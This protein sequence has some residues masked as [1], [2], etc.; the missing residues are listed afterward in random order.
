MMIIQR[1]SDTMRLVSSEDGS[2]NMAFDPMTGFMARWGRTR[3]EDPDLSPDGPEIL[4]VEVSTVCNRG[5]KFCYKG[6]TGRGR[7]MT[8][9]T[10][11]RILAQ[12]PDTLT[13]VAL[14][15]G[16]I[17]A[18]PDL[19]E[20][21]RLCRSRGV[22]PNITVNGR[23]VTD[24][25]VR[26][27]ASLCGAVAVS[28]YSDDECF[29]CVSK[30][31]DAGLKQVNIHQLLSEETFPECLRLIREA[32]SDER[33]KGKLRAIVFL[34]LKPK[35]P[36]NRLTPLRSIESYRTLVGSAMESGVAFGFD[37]CS[38]PMAMMSLDQ[39]FHQSID[40]CESLL[41]S[42]YINVDGHA[43][44]CS[45]SEGVGDWSTGIDLTAPGADFVRDVWTSPRARAWRRRLLS[46]SS[47]CKSC[48]FSSSCR[49][50][51]L[52]EVSPCRTS[53]SVT[54]RS[55]AGG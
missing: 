49:S 35:G 38:A 24:E 39:R 6:N 44:P 36:R 42:G 25:H 30:L 20:I 19:F 55:T 46:S 32:K 15:I 9:P 16:D 22:V 23:G 54:E 7:N 48:P 51:P 50:C 52:Y 13:Q 14:G 4:D 31:S 43:F 17:D 45:F 34:A 29:S 5:C 27:L 3:D 37:S 18:N 33:L 40:P 47:G 10:F 21:M 12:M 28:H 1:W 11:G 26:L 2:Y 8:A 53:S 41:F